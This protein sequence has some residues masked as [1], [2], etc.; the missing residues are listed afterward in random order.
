MEGADSCF[1]LDSNVIDLV[2][3]AQH[4]ESTS[5]SASLRHYC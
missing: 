2:D 1:R 3:A 4:L 5:I